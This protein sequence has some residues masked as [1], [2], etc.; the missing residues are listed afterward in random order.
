MTK[1]ERFNDIV[2]YC[3]TR[4]NRGDANTWKHG[5]FVDL[6]Q[7]IMRDTGVN[8]S[9]STLKRI[10][11]KVS[12]DEEYVPQ[13][14]TLDA[15]KKYG[16][17]A[18]P[19]SPVPVLKPP[20]KLKSPE[21][22][23]GFRRYGIPLFLIIAT[24]CIAG[25]IIWNSRS[26]KNISGDIRITG[27][28][29]HIPAT[30]FFDLQLPET[31]D[32]LFVNYGDKSPLM[33]LKPGEKKAAHIYYFPGVFNVSLQT[34]QQPLATTVAYI[35]SDS[36]IGFGFH[37]QQDIP[38]QFFE[39]PAVKNSGD[40]LFQ[41]TNRQVSERG[42]DTT[43]VLLIRLCNYTPVA[44]NADDFIFEATF[45]NALEEKYNYCRSTQFQISGSNS[46]I[47]FK[48]VGPGCSQRVLNV[49]SEQSF[50]GTTNNLSQFVLDLSRWNTV[51]LVNHNRRVSLYVNGKQLFTGEYQ[52][53]LGDIRGL[54]LEFEGAGI[55]KSCDL[56][57]YDGRILYH[58]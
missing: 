18:E 1:G 31:G 17:Y 7:E 55:V 46:M 29:G 3:R 30:A 14:A 20:S 27:T 48:L 5:D 21:T 53:P 36:W 42:L 24:A 26:P 25:F 8:I 11:G 41:I 6:H 49:V 16:N 12:V 57:S 15:L 58:F 13:Q 19:V 54:F 52:K 35:R 38:N 2:K 37:N 56:R 40:S 10:F 22:G 32:S 33:Y 4:F 51:K 47:R 34:R 39:F 43:G 23:N 44:Q 28:E 45:K 9:P 50:S